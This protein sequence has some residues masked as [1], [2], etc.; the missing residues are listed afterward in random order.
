MAQSV[1]RNFLYNFLYQIL[2]ILIPLVT[3]PYL[4]R[5]LGAKG[6]GSYSY[7][8]S[9]AQYFVIFAVLGVNNY[10][11]RSVASV[12]D[13]E[14]TLKRVFTEIYSTQVLTSLVAIAAYLG[15]LFLGKSDIYKKIMALYVL[16]AVLDVNWFF[17][18]I[19]QFRVTVFRNACIKLLS[20]S[21]IFI[22]VRDQN[23]AWI[24]CFVMAASALISQAVLWPFVFKRFGIVK[25]DFNSC[26]IHLK[27]MLI[28][29]I[30]VIAVS[31]YKYMDKIMLGVYSGAQDVGFYESTERVLNVPLALVSAL[32]TVMLPKTANLLSNG[33][34]KLVGKSIQKSIVFSVA[35]SSVLSIGIASVANEFVPVFF[36]EGF[37]PCIELFYILMPSCVFVA[38]ANVLRT[39]YLIP[40]KKDKDF[41]ISVLAGAATNFVINFFLIPVMGASGAAIGTLAAEFAVFIIQALLLWNELP[42]AKYIRDSVIVLMPSIVMLLVVRIV[43]TFVDGIAGIAVEIFAGAIVWT[44]IMILLWRGASY[45]RKRW[46]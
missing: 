14:V 26:M 9:V 11:N 46:S 24:Y 12:R 32:G 33:K 20:T 5:V 15:Y 28:L 10:G 43:A 22:L 30:P 7:A 39:Q 27:P 45:I 44:F 35:V 34:E 41:V 8:Y 18:G 31:L 36:G 40:K 6:I 17:F 1:K 23:S 4:T 16:S 2:N 21:L 38:F 25:L 3:T 29:F 19:E 42:V 37:E 13:D